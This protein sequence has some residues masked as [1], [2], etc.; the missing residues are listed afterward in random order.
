[1]EAVKQEA[2]IAA[3]VAVAGALLLACGPMS[4][5]AGVGDWPMYRGDAAGTG[6]SALA[7]I[8]TA[9]V[10][11]LAPVWRR[12]LASLPESVDGGAVQTRPARSQATPIVVG[13]L[14][15]VPTAD[16]VVALDPATGDTVWTFG[17]LGSGTS[18][19]R[20]GVAYWAGGGT[21]GWAPRILV[22]AGARLIALDAATGVPAV[23]FG[24]RGTVDIGVPY[25][26]VPLVWEDIVVVGANTPPGTAG[27]IGN[28][29]AFSA[30]TGEKLWEFNSVAQPGEVGHQT[31]EGES[32]RGR[33]GGNAWPF[34]FTVDEQRALV[35][36][37]L[38]APIPFAWGGDRHGAN[39]FANSVVAV[40]IHT[41]EYRWHF[42][43]IHHDIWDHD[44]PAPPVL[45]EVERAGETIDALAVTTKSGYLFVLNRENGEPVFGV[46]ERPM[47]ASQVPGERTHP[48][49]PIPS[50]T[51]AL[52]RVGYGAGDLVTATET[53]A[54]HAEACAEL[55]ESAGPLH[56]AGPYTPWMHRGAEDGGATLLFPGLAGGP[57][58][59]GVAFD[60][61]T[62]RLLAFSQDVGTMG[63]VE[64]DTEAESVTYVLRVARP[65]SFAVRIGDVSWPCQKPPWGT[66]TAVDADT[67]EVAWRRPLGVTE[68]LPAEKRETGRPG[69]ASAIVTAGGLAFI[70]ATDDRRFRALDV[71]TGDELWSAELPLQGNANPMTYLAADGRQYVAVTATEELLVF[72][73]P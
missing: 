14:M 49:Q 8:T 66:L 39:L 36:L 5:E 4:N 53:T 58:W 43:T 60:P 32:W 28:A 12:S 65:F 21:E 61:A 59:G 30:V 17:L 1:M 40:D 63:W 72:R 26:S 37:P 68:G 13:G 18:L 44:P 29:R 42:Q 9:N 2:K 71:E 19:S 11:H 6:Y 7:E 15:Y 3:T 20:R 73:L 57:N 24:P 54:E 70:A 69:R 48:T 23:E 51:P 33:L 45:F 25:N 31:W 27:G 10:A 56:N 64:E 67:G 52:G 62:R 50:V 38:A 41:G 22:T 47:P 34:Y 16:S 35:F 46:E 55:V